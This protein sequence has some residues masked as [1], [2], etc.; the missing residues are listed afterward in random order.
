M[1]NAANIMRPSQLCAELT[2]LE[3]MSTT[4]PDAQRVLRDERMTLQL[5]LEGG[6]PTH[7][8]R[9]AAEAQRVLDMWRPYL[10]AS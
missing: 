6:N 2:W 10:G 7:I 9:D 4:P 1:S 3:V 8:A 5:S